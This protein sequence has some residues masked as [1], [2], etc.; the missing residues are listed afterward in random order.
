[1]NMWESN[2]D[3][4]KIVEAHVFK[5]LYAKRR[6]TFI[7]SLLKSY[8]LCVLPIEKLCSTENFRSS[9]VQV[10]FLQEYQLSYV[11]SNQ[12][13]AVSSRINAAENNEKSSG[14]L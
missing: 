2:H 12:L 9:I 8:S 1:M 4:C 10:F 7:Y 11:F 3:A 14:V 5:H 13:C 6:E